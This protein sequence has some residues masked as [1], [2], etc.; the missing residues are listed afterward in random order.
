LKLTTLNDFNTS[1]YKFEFFYSPT[2]LTLDYNKKIIK[3]NFIDKIYIYINELIIII[4]TI[5][6]K[7]IYY[8]ICLFNYFY[9]FNI[10]PTNKT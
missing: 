2:H 7:I 10:L 1:F 8:K 3:I 4:K 5:E 6:S 9:V